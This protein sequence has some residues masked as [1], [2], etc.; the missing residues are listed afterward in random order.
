[1]NEY[2]RAVTAEING[3][4][5]ALAK[6]ARKTIITRPGEYDQHSD[7]VGVSVD[8]DP[9]CGQ[10]D[11]DDFFDPGGRHVMRITA[12]APS[13]CGEKGLPQISFKVTVA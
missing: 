5:V 2:G 6:G 7:G 9:T 1:M 3:Q 12:G 10:G 11:G 13:G 4:K 8:E